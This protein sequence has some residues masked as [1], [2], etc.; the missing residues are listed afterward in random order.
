MNPYERKNG[1]NETHPPQFHR[2][3]QIPTAVVITFLAIGV[4]IGFA[5]VI[6]AFFSINP[7]RSC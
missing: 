2:R 4:L 3:R 7:F 1:F 6:I 5:L